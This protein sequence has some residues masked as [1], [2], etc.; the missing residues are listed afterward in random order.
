VN[1]REEAGDLTLARIR[2]WEPVIQA[3]A[4]IDA[5]AAV[6]PPRPGASSLPLQG[7][8]FGVKDMIDVTG[9]PTRFGSAA[10]PDA[11]PARRDAAIVDLLRRAGAIPIGKTRTTEFAFIDPTITRNPFDPR[12]SPGGSSSGSA[13]VVGAGLVPFA[14]GTQTAG[15]LCRPAIYCGAAAYKPSHGILP[16]DGLAPLSPSFDTIGVIATTAGWLE[17]L[18]AILA[19]GFGLPELPPASRAQRLRI[20]LLQTPEQAPSAALRG[21][22]ADACSSLR[23]AGHGVFDLPAPLSFADVIARHRIVMLAEAARH[24]GALIRDRE[25]AL[26]PKLRAAL[27]EGSRIGEDQR[28]DALAWLAE[29]RRD[30]WRAASG[31]DLLLAYPVPDVAPLGLSTTGDQSY[32]TPWT[33][34]GGP[35]VALPAGLSEEGLPLGLLLAAAPGRDAAL[36]QAAGRIADLLPPPASP[37][38]PGS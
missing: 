11:M 8:P 21:M 15:S 19:A 38:F 14:L 7:I 1:K 27:Q 37:R 16:V 30:F 2:L 28:L 20:G 17:R 24:V 23:Q 25:A 29:A 26:Q 36:I 3:W 22:M 13:A 6:M 33:A 31:F 18:Y 34:L 4:H 32:L 5:P 12:R 9:Q 10:F 35:L